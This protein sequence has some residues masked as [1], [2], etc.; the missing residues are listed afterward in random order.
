MPRVAESFDPQSIEWRHITDPNEKA[1]LID[2]KPM[3]D[4]LGLQK[5]LKSAVLSSKIKVFAFLCGNP[6]KLQNGAPSWPQVGPSWSQVG[7]KWPKL[8]PS[9]L[10]IDF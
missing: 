3:L 7:P 10:E 9:G 4:H 8:A 2:F 1:F 6:K 5:T